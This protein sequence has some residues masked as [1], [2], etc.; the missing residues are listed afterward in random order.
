MAVVFL[1]DRA[2]P[3]TART[4]AHEQTVTVAAVD[5]IFATAIPF[6]LTAPAVRLR[7]RT[8]FFFF[9]FFSHDCLLFLAPALHPKGERE[10]WPADVRRERER[11]RSETRDVNA[12]AAAASPR[13]EAEGA[14]PEISNS[15][16]DEQG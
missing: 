4:N 5:T 16:D 7:A 9:Y 11:E 2:T 1:I 10:G 14:R 15:F 13:R 12:N 6:F 3:P 8:S